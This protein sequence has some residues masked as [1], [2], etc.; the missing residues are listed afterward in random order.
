[1]RTLCPVSELSE[2]ALCCGSH[3]LQDSKT[4]CLTKQ[5]YAVAACA[6]R[7]KDLMS[8]KTALC[9]GSLVL[10]R[11]KGLLSFSHRPTFTV[12]V[13][14]RIE[15]ASAF[16][17]TKEQHNSL[18]KECVT[19]QIKNGPGNYSRPNEGE[20]SLRAIRVQKHATILRT[21]QAFYTSSQLNVWL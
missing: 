1:M 14:L 4:L 16:S 8:Y 12:L 7:I 9:C 11:R 10:Q 21:L 3:V 19:R 20:T 18:A 2:S 15:S 17:T 6:A 13:M 5:P